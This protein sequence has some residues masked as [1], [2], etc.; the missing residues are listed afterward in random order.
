M[1]VV[2]YALVAIAAVLFYEMFQRLHVMTDVQR[3]FK[4]APEALSVIGSAT[5]SDDD[6]ESAVR[7]L[8]V[9]VL[10]DTFRFTG[11]MLIV[12]AISAALVWAG[13]LLFGIESAL[14][15]PLLLSWEVL[16]GLVLL[17][18]LYSRVRGALQSRMSESS[19][20]ANV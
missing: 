13:A 15:L 12:F 16:V 17:I 4:V 14:L 2:A 5:L 9:K 1:S 6:K 19:S 7:K 3:V 20:T 10:L 11:K 18:A 8:A